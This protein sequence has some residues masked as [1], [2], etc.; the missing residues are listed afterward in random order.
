MDRLPQELVEAI[1]S[2]LFIDD[3]KNVLTLS[4]NFRFATERYSG[5][6]TEFTV[7]ESNADRFVE[8]YS[9]HR[10]LY[11]REVHFR[12]N[13][14]PLWLPGDEDDVECRQSED[15]IRE[16]SECF[17]RQV[18]SLFTTL[19][20]VEKNAGHH[21]VPG[22]YRLLMHD[23]TRLFH[24]ENF[25]FH[26]RYSS[27]RVRLLNTELPLV[28]SVRSM[29]IHNECP[30]DPK[31]YH[32]SHGYP[33]NYIEKFYGMELKLDLGLMIDLA[34]KLPDLEYL[35]CKT[36]GFEWHPPSC[37]QGTVAKNP[38]DTFR[39]IG[40]ARVVMRGIILHARL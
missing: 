13:F 37:H 38:T 12:P 23:P 34:P 14:P 33:P 36:G 27:W 24:Q 2:H 1:T 20:T 6:F 25:C 35:G 5:A 22:R 39:V 8:R 16:N 18:H 31:V 21:Y 26:R 19:S 10:L 15:N 3:L 28:H 7:N 4:A 30:E 17:T 11:L 40:M 29:E 9:G 32:D